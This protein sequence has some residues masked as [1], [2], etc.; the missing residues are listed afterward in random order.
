MRASLAGKPPRCW[1]ESPFGFASISF[2]GTRLIRS[3]ERN[4]D[5]FQNRLGRGGKKAAGGGEKLDGAERGRI[6]ASVAKEI[7]P[8]VEALKKTANAS[9][10]IQQ[11]LLWAAKDQLPKLFS[12]DGKVLGQCDAI[13]QRHMY[14][15]G[16]RL[17]VDVSLPPTSVVIQ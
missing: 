14:E 5:I 1:G 15:A 12:A 10:P 7:K 8:I 9:D 17:G 4:A 6:A 3:A 11:H 13:F 16:R 2:C